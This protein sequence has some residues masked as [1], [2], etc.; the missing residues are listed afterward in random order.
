MAYNLTNLT[1]AQYATDLIDATNTATDGIIGIGF[2]IS[3]FVIVLMSLNNLTFPER[4]AISSF[5]S[6]FP[7]LIMS[8]AGWL[9]YLF[10][11]G[12]L[13]IAGLSALFLKST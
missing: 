9:N 10:P 4:L 13:L 1:N 11:V 6:F 5:V 3:V 8:F 12:L 2:I 7:A